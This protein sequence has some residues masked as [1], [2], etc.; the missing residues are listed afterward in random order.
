MSHCTFELIIGEPLGKD[1]LVL[2]L[3][4]CEYITG[5]VIWAE[6]RLEVIWHC[7]RTRRNKTWEFILC[8]DF[9][10]FKAIGAVFT[11]RKDYDL[12]GKGSLHLNWFYGSE[13]TRE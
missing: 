5:P 9:V 6:Q 8:D 1:N 2:S 13:K 10:G 3:A 11:W 7:D 12:L 4:A